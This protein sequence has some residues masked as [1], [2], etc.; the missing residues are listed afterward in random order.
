MF[1]NFY[2]RVFTSVYSHL[3]CFFCKF[4]DLSGISNLCLSLP[5]YSLKHHPLFF[6]LFSFRFAFSACVWCT[7]LSV[8]VFAC[9][10]VQMCVQRSGQELTAGVFLDL[11]SLVRGG[12]AFLLN[13][14]LIS[15][16]NTTYPTLQCAGIT[17]RIVA[18][19]P[20]IPFV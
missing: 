3:N 2:L 6:P 17:D 5:Y 11:F 9:K 13:L 4:P 19:K 18:A 8:Y 14:A 20:P 15:A 1:L 10:Y 12:G 7:Y 16:R